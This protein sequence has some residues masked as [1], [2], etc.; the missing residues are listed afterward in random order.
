MKLLIKHIKI[1]V[2]KHAFD[3]L[4][5]F[6]AGVVFLT[7][8]NVFR[9]ERLLE[10]IILLSFVSFYIIWGIYHHIIEDSLHMKIVLEYILIGFAI[11]FLI[12]VLIFP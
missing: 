8:L 11:L 10:F 2:K 6:T 4:L 12:K 5:F 7:G 1:E 3:Y 9:G